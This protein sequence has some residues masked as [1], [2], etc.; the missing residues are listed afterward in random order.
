[1]RVNKEVKTYDGIRMGWEH[2]GVTGRVW[3]F[4]VACADRIFSVR[5]HVLL[6]RV[7]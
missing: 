3:S 6:E 5:E 7:K 4:D 2:D 1:M